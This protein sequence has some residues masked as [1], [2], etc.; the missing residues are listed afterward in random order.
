AAMPRATRRL[1]MCPSPQVLK[2]IG[3][4]SDTRMTRGRPLLGARASRPLFVSQGTDAGETPIGANFG[5]STSLLTLRRPAR[6]V[7]E[8]RRS[9]RVAT[10][11]V[12]R[13]N[14]CRT[15]GVV[16]TLRD[17]RFAHSSG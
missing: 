14:H 10:D 11:S 1:T 9:R 7:A 5:C 6:S 12:V 17:A 8:E 13:A 15:V 16:P 4:D 2:L 3:W